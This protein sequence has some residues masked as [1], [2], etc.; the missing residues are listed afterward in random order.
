MI[1]GLKG[2]LFVDKDLQ[3]RSAYT[4]SYR[5]NR[6]SFGQSFQDKLGN[7]L[8]FNGDKSCIYFMIE[9]LILCIPVM[10][11]KMS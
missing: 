10:S 5:K 3:W 1:V 11:S 7:Y 6:I 8:N 4:D 2:E 9:V